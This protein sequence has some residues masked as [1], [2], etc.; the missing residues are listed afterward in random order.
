MATEDHDFAEINYFSFKGKIQMEQ[1]KHGPVG[2]LSTE[3][4][5]KCLKF[6]HKKLGSSTMCFEKMFS[7]AYLKHDNLRMPHV[8]GQCSLDLGLVILD[9]DNQDLKRSFIP[10]AKELL[11][12]TSL[13]T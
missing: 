11:Q 4:P 7:E 8:I 13:G 12:Q 6:M 3:G 5:L 9:A 10:Y 2:R 1:R